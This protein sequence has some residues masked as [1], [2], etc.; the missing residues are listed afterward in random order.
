MTPSSA[1]P[2]AAT[3][4]RRPTPPTPST[5]IPAPPAATSG[6]ISPGDLPAA[7]N[8]DN[9]T[10]L[11]EIGHTLGLKHPHEAPNPLASSLD[12][13]EFTVMTYR[14]YVGAKPDYYKNGSVDYPQTYMQLD[15]AAL[16]HLYGADFTTSAGDTTYS[17][18]PKTGET[19]VDGAVAI[20]PAGNRI[21]A[22][23]WDGGGS[24]HLRSL[25]P[26][27]PLSPSISAPGKASIFDSRQLADLGGGPNGGDARGNIFN[28]LQYRAT[29]LA[30]RERQGRQ[31]RR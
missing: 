16:Q 15:I 8:Y 14:S 2:T 5:P 1:S 19:R 30:D 23:I 3:R 9:H 21:F 17:W 22:T 28:A 31:R 18:N 25:E 26:T 7:G 4:R 10:I 29:P 20:A 12:S 27:P 13:L 6:S 24:R 11:H